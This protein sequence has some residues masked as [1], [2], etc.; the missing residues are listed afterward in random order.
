VITGLYCDNTTCHGFLRASAGT[1]TT[2]DVPGSNYTESDAINPP[3]AIAGIYQPGLHGYLRATDGT[4][5]SFDVPGSAYT[6]R[7]AG[8]TPAG[9]IAG[10]YLTQATGQPCCLEH[11]FLRS[12]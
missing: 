6:W 2:I 12:P 3:R 5:T 8:I 9:A 4:F 10:S 11:G 1:F 7:I